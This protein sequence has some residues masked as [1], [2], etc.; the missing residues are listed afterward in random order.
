MSYHLVRAFVFQIE[1]F[2]Y[3]RYLNLGYTLRDSEIIQKFNNDVN[4]NE[5]M[6]IN[7]N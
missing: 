1:L 7:D 2:T 4:D 3:L 5:D 6:I